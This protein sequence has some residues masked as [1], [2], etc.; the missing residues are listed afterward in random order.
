MVAQF[1]TGTIMAGQHG[2]ARNQ[3]WK[4]EKLDDFTVLCTLSANEQTLDVWPHK[5]VLL[6]K[7][8]V[9]RGELETDFRVENPVD[10]SGPFSFTALL[11]TYF[12]V[13]HIENVTVTGLKDTNYLDKLHHGKEKVE[14]RE[15]A[16]VQEEVDRIYVHVP[17][18]IQL[19]SENGIV[20]I[21][22]KGFPDVVFWNPWSEKSKSMA[23][24]D[25]HEVHIMPLAISLTSTI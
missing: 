9:R 15:A 17:D 19:A 24:F 16:T 8:S 11:H 6:Y 25:D 13:G 22:K 3:V 10:S 14:T 12:A 18:S 7:V 21:G 5:F 23:D 2:F 20:N 1:G 4:V